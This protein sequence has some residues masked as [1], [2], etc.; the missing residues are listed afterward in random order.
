LL[1]FAQ[2]IDLKD[3]HEKLDD[4]GLKIPKAVIVEFF[5]QQGVNFVN[6]AKKKRKQA[7]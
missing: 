4:A 6:T 3:I 2:T 1:R 5:M 7:D